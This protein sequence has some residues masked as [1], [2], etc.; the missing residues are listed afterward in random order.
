MNH[1]T[2]LLEAQCGKESVKF[3]MGQNGCSFAVDEEPGG[4]LVVHTPMPGVIR[5]FS[6]DCGIDRSDYQPD[7]EPARRYDLRE[8]FSSAQPNQRTCIVDVMVSWELPEGVTSEYPLSGLRGRFYYRH[9]P[10][11]RI[12]VE[13]SWEPWYQSLGGFLGVAWGQFRSQPTVA[14]TGEPAVLKLRLPE[15]VSQGSYR[16]YG[17]GHGVENQSFEGRE[18]V[19]SRDAVLGPNPQPGGCMLFGFMTGTKA[20]G[21]RILADVVAAVEIF[22]YRA[23]RLAVEIY[24]NKYRWCYRGESAISL[25]TWETQAGRRRSFKSA[26]CFPASDGRMSFFT[27]K[28]RAAYAVTK[29]DTFEVIQ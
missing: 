14:T 28:G 20:D 3:G 12:A 29:G 10:D 17:C 9:R 1:H 27:H 25:A 24:R 18:V 4:E 6:R 8:L 15:A 13:A 2:A 7:G 21:S 11:P 16:L 26:D 5:L 23:M 19:V 22:D